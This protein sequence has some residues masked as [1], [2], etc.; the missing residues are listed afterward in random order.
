MTLADLIDHLCA[1]AHAQTLTDLQVIR[2]L[3]L[4]YDMGLAQ[5]KKE[6]RSAPSDGS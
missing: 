4:A 3:L 5:G 1:G 6:A 2:A